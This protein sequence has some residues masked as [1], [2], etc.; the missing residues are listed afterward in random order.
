[1][2]RHLFM[3]VAVASGDAVG[4]AKFGMPMLRCKYEQPVGIKGKQIS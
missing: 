4:D 1:M 2:S 3:R